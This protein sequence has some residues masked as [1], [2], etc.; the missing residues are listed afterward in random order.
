MHTIK[1][2]LP[3]DVIYCRLV[4]ARGALQAAKGFKVYSGVKWNG[5]EKMRTRSSKRIL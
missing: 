1:I 3:F 4:E 2:I 5:N